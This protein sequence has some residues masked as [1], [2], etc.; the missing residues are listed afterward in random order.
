M[1]SKLLD[2]PYWAELDKCLDYL[3][4]RA[5]W[6]YTDGRAPI[7]QFYFILKSLLYS[8]NEIKNWSTPNFNRKLA[9]RLQYDNTASTTSRRL[10]KAY[11]KDLRKDPDFYLT[12]RKSILQTLTQEKTRKQIDPIGTMERHDTDLELLWEEVRGVVKC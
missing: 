4:T 1:I 3:E 9:E 10:T 5:E 6:F 8:D 12:L 11:F 2:E 7:Y